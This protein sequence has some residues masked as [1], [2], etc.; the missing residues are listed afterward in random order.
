MTIIA[1]PSTGDP[2]PDEVATVKARGHTFDPTDV[3]IYEFL[4]QGIPNPLDLEGI[5]DEKLLE[6]QQ[7]IQDKLKQ[8]M[9]KE[10]GILQRE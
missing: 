3:H 6:I 7:N 9:K 2:P 1:E 8:K 5:D 10:K 4:I